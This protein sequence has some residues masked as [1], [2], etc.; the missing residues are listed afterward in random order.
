MAGRVITLANPCL[1]STPK[2]RDSEQHG[3]ESLHFFS[4]FQGA[5]ATCVQFYPC[6]RTLLA[7]QKFFA[8]PYWIEHT[9][10]FVKGILHCM[11]GSL[12]YWQETLPM[13]EFRLK[14]PGSYPKD[15]GG[16]TLLSQEFVLG[17]WASH[18]VGHGRRKAKLFTVV[19]IGSI[20]QPPPPSWQLKAEFLPATKEEKEGGKVGSNYRKVSW[21]GIWGHGGGGGGWSQFLNLKKYSIAFLHGLAIMAVSVKSFLIKDGMLGITNPHTIT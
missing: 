7:R 19:G 21:W 2:G 20:V 4:D 16:D 18:S 5:T 10:S 8:V 12:G 14:C 6:K 3:C 17:R 9:F 1:L 13:S 11:G 15:E